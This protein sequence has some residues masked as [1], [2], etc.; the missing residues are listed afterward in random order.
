MRKVLSL[1]AQGGLKL[2]TVLLPQFPTT[3]GESLLLKA[4]HSWP[5]HVLGKSMFP[6]ARAVLPW[7]AAQVASTRRKGIHGRDMK[8]SPSDL[9][10]LLP[11]PQRVPV[12]AGVAQPHSCPLVE[13]AVEDR[14]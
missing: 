13:V 3:P 10:E 4:E 7:R 2:I 8:W 11:Q 1:Q 6:G 12:K 9:H 14:R 5:E